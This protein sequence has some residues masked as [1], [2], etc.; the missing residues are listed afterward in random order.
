MI[1]INEY[2]LSRKSAKD[3]IDSNNKKFNNESLNIL[4]DKC[5]MTYGDVND[6]EVIISLQTYEAFIK[7]YPAIEDLIDYLAKIAVKYI[8]GEPNNY[9]YINIR[10]AK[11]HKFKCD[12]YVITLR[13]NKDYFIQVTVWEDYKVVGFVWHDEDHGWTLDFWGDN[14]FSPKPYS[15]SSE[16]Y[17]TINKETIDAIIKQIKEIETS[18]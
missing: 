16:Y 18:L 15:K 6:K 3:F 11:R 17:G 13:F 8:N 14:D 4:Y 2:L 10:D 7:S 5:M 12:H 9:V 1:H